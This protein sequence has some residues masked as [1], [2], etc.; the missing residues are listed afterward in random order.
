MAYWVTVSVTEMRWLPLILLLWLP[1]PVLAASYNKLDSIVAVVDEDLVM[2]SE[3]EAKIKQVLLQ[4]RR[5]GVKLPPRDVIEQKVLEQLIVRRLQ[6]NAAQR[7]GI[8]VDEGLVAKAIGGIAQRNGLNIGQFRTALER[9]G[10]NYNVFKQGIEEEFLLNRLHS[11]QV[12]SKISVSEQEI[13]AFLSKEA[14]L[15][16]AN[17]SYQVGH[18]LIRVAEGAE[19]AQLVKAREQAEGVVRK[20]R[21]GEDFAEVAMQSSTAGNALEGG[22]L[23][24]KKRSE[25]PSAIADRVPLLKVGEVSD[26]IRGSGGYHVVKLINRKGETQRALVDQTQVRHI[27]IRTNELTSDDDAKTRLEQLRVRIVGGDDFAALA[28]AHSNDTAS[29]IKGGDLG[30]LGANDVLPEFR[31]QMDA[32]QPKEV[33]QPFKTQMGWHLLQ[34]LERR[35]YDSTDDLRRNQASAAIKQRK[36]AE[37]IEQFVRQLRDEAYVEIRLNQPELD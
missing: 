26:P 18:I 11:Q 1:L 30:W 17:V 13:N 23:G 31:Q 7:A 36:G 20:L 14:R 21:N 34:V 10:I 32:L 12:L 9:E 2:R 24:W 22:D 4:N 6:L 35:N 25:L 37:A 28:R 16:D 8:A 15:G 19:S 3:L 27:L 29:A 33:S 5:P